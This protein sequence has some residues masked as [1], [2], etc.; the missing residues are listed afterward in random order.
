MYC[1]SYYNKRYLYQYMA[2]LAGCIAVMSSGINLGWTSPYLPEILNGT[3][4]D[5]SMTSDEGSWCAIMPLIGAIPG[6]L[7]TMLAVDR[8]GRK[9]TVLIMAPVTFGAFVWLAFSKSGVV[10]SVLRFIIGSVEGGLYTALPMYLGEISDS[11]VRGILTASMGLFSI[12]GA[13]FINVLGF[14]YTIFES[15]L[16]CACVPLLHFLSFVWMPESPYY[17]IKKGNKTAAETS[18]KIFRNA[19]SV[20]EELDEMVKAVTRQESESKA[21]FTDLVTIKSNRRAVV[22]YLIINFARKFSGKN[23]IGFYTLD[24]F[25][26][27]D[28][29]LS[30]YTSVVIFIGVEV[31]AAMIGIL[32]IDRLGRRPLVIASIAVCGVTLGLMGTYFLLKDA[33]ASY[34]THLRWLPL[35]SLVLYN[36]FYT[37][38]L[39]L[40]QTTY[41][42]ELFPTNIKAIA[43]GLADVVS[44]IN[45]AIVSKIFQLIADNFGIHYSFYVLSLACLTALILSVIYVIETKNK[46]LEEIQLCLVKGSS[47]QK[48]KSPN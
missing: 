2:T 35:T 48:R 42:G 3:Y 44:V 11:E 39:E 21:K 23:P 24:I 46:T 6:A 29:D 1:H 4:P 25:R 37:L 12:L 8:I 43:L 15:S 32:V 10:I 27:A 41:L 14:H 28:G 19:E 47:I 16:A 30:E 17:Y 9:I 31:C 33:V 13:L 45:G 7:L 34:I 22:I 40:A 36:T 18:L 20:A 38:G 26:L 5:I